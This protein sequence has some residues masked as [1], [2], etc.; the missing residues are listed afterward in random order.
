MDD[1]LT[2]LHSGPTHD[3]QEDRATMLRAAHEI[4][5]LQVQLE[6]ARHDRGAGPILQPD[7]HQGRETLSQR[8][9]G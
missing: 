3:T 8:S 1:L 6:D 5:R 4:Q 9:H 2:K 7:E